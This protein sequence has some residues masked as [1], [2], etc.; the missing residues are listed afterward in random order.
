MAS[1]EYFHE[2][3]EDQNLAPIEEAN[4][5]P[6]ERH[7]QVVESNTGEPGNH[8]DL[9]EIPEI[10][11]FI[12]TA[13][14]TGAKLE[15]LLVVTEEIGLDPIAAEDLLKILQDLGIEV[16]DEI[17][18]TN[19]GSIELAVDE[20]DESL[21]SLQLFLR[22]IGKVDLLTAAK[23]VELSKLIESGKTAENVI[24]AYLE[25]GEVIEA[26]YKRELHARIDAGEKAKKHLIEA[27]LRLV[28]SIAK[29]YIGKG[30]SLLDLIQEG[31][32]GLDRA[33]EKF[34]WRRGY[35]FSTYATWWIRQAVQRG[36]ANDEHTIR[37]PIHIV[38]YSSKINRA[39]RKLTGSLGREPMRGEI[40]EESGLT[41][42]K[43][44]SVMNAARV[45]MS[46]D[47]PSN[48]EEGEAEVMDFFADDS[49][50][51]PEDT[52]HSTIRQE[53]LDKILEILPERN[54]QIIILRYGL[55]GESCTLEEIGQRLGITRERVR[56]I[57]IT[58]LRDLQNL[59]EAQVLREEIT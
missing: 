14:E 4:K 3:A 53:V 7:L 1:S 8:L 43:Y 10:Q 11:D 17:S 42:Q 47:Q 49:E 23:E 48:N 32:L 9:Q 13:S 2:T 51:L 52:V 18:L 20:K 29:R 21:D 38:E 24:K 50:P 46:L 25:G 44:D 56:Q 31:T 40:I 12:M 45:V 59:R 37:L 33:A 15:D 19:N 36:L 58:S 55:N 26:A 28:V 5:P 34:D 39:R 27:N 57:E 16:H 30:L 22:D 41:E 54:R 35:K 6:A